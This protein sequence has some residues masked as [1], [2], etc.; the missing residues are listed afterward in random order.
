[1]RMLQIR[2]SPQNLN[3]VKQIK[4]NQHN[5]SLSDLLLESNQLDCFV[6][7]PKGTCPSS[8]QLQKLRT[9]LIPT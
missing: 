3:H 9:F 1:M 5:M 6:N 2:S 8:H 7:I 4:R